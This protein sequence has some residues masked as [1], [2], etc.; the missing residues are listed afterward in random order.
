MYDILYLQTLLYTNFYKYFTVSV[1]P[2]SFC[3]LA[4]N[5]NK[6]KTKINKKK[7]K[8]RS[9]ENR[10]NEKQDGLFVDLYFLTHLLQEQ[11]LHS[12]KKMQRFVI[13]LPMIWSI[14]LELT[15]I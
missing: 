10:K 11:W 6:K 4:S 15:Q 1:L 12:A 7:Q 13:I 2:L 9:K 8:L 14:R 5:N 3:Y